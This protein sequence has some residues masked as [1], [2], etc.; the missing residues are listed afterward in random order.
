ML[1][2]EDILNKHQCATLCKNI[3][4]VVKVY[5]YLMACTNDGLN[6]G[7]LLR[8]LLI[9]LD[10]AYILVKNCGKKKWCKAAQQ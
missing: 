2:E 3:E 9:T 6:Y 10:K 5:D 8:E 4:H 1:K 7:D